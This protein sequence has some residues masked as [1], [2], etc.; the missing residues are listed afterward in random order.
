MLRS[1]AGFTLWEL[2]WTMLIVSIALGLGVPS[3]RTFALDARRTADVNAFVLAV[4]LA[5]NEAAKRGRPVVVCASSDRASCTNP[6]ATYDAGWIVFVNED[7]A[8]PPQR[9]LAEPLLYVHEPEMAGTITAN[10][11]RFE[12]WPFHSRRST[13]GTVV[14][15]DARGPGAA[16]AAIVSYTGRPRVDSAAPDGGPLPCAGLP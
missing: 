13:N 16:R 11:E 2:L 6:K 5:R 15:C 12:F 7:G 3:F 14:F 4:Q 10:R 9:S 8:R 1:S